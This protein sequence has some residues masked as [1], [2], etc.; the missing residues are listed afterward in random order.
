MTHPPLSPADRRRMVDAR[1]VLRALGNGTFDPQKE[2]AALADEMCRILRRADSR[3]MV[4][5]GVVDTLKRLVFERD[6]YRAMVGLGEPP[7][8]TGR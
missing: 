5:E 1:D 2:A 4:T 7:G 3:C 8:E 6:L